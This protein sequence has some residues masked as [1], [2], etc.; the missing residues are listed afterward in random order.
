MLFATLIQL[1]SLKIPLKLIL[2]ISKDRKT[3]GEPMNNSAFDLIHN[4]GVF[5]KRV[6]WK[7]NEVAERSAG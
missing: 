2:S 3:V 5:V 6:N 4:I 7:G 1:S